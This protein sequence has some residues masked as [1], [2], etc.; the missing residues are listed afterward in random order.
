MLKIRLPPRDLILNVVIK[1]KRRGT[2]ILQ[3]VSKESVNHKLTLLFRRKDPCIVISLTHQRS[4][5]FNKDPIVVF[6]LPLIWL[7]DLKNKLEAT[8]RVLLEII[9][10]IMKELRQENLLAEMEAAIVLTELSVASIS[11]RLRSLLEVALVLLDSFPTSRA[12]D[13]HKT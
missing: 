7:K 1:Q 5:A 11:F 12:T 13:R 8:A 4:L 6:S 9:K 2:L 10:R 3:S